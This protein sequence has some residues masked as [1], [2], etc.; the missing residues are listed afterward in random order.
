M[1]WLAT[2]QFL[3]G[4]RK[5]LIFVPRGGKLIALMTNLPE[6]SREKRK[7]VIPTCILLAILKG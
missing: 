5:F 3:F 6:K 1:R 4:G 7:S 2:V